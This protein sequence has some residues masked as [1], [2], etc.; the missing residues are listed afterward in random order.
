LWKEGTQVSFAEPSGQTG[1]LLPAAGENVPIRFTRS[2]DGRLLYAI[3]LQW[4]GTAL[5][6][7]TIRMN[8]SAKITL[9]GVK[10][11]LNWHD[12]HG[13]GL[14]IEI[15]SALQDEVKRPCKTAWA[16]KVEGEEI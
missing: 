12:D 1:E 10:Q 8:K 6:L 5:K 11:Q 2:K 14:V 3:C 4:P 16:F 15:P 9:L 7:Q 13:G